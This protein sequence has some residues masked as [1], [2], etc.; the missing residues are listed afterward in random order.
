MLPRPLDTPSKFHEIKLISFHYKPAIDDHFVR[1]VDM[2]KFK[3]ISHTHRGDIVWIDPGTIFKRIIRIDLAK[4]FI[5][6]IHPI[7]QIEFIRI[8]ALP[9]NERIITL[10]SHQ[11]VMPIPANQGIVGS[12][13]IQNFITIG[14]LDRRKQACQ[15]GLGPLGAIR[16]L[17]PVKLIVTVAVVGGEPFLDHDLVSTVDM[18]QL[19]M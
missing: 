16:E 8:G 10:A 11:R 12:T 9:P 19:K 4:S 15:I 2:P 5:Y 7:T 14:S 13:P 6:G 18:P 17:N 3:I 1:P